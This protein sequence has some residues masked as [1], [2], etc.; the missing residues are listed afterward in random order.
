MQ[1]PVFLYLTGSDT[2]LFL[3][4]ALPCAIMHLLMPIFTGRQKCV[5]VVCDVDLLYIAGNWSLNEEKEETDDADVTFD[6][7]AKQ[8]GI[9]GLVAEKDLQVASESVVA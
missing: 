5:Q 1:V 7:F 9:L 4:F 2:V 3:Q 6:V 8:N